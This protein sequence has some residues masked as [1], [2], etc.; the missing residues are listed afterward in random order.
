V[1][2]V[3]AIV[4]HK[5]GVGKTTSAV[6]IAACWGEIGKRVLVIDLDPQG[7]A[8]LSFGIDDDGNALL[9]ALQKT[10]AL[11]VLSTKASGV[12]LVPAGRKVAEAR[13]R[14]VGAIGSELL[15]R[16]LRHTE[17][18]WDFVIIDCP[19]SLGILTM[20][21]LKA[22]AHVVIPVEA[23]Y[24]SY[25]G[26]SQMF[27]AVNTF[28]SQNPVL[29]IRAIIPCRAQARRR[30]HG[31]FLEMMEK[32]LPGGIGPMIRENVSL[33]EAP[34][35]GLPV[36]L[37]FPNSNGAYDYRRAAQWLLERLL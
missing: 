35:S 2:Q 4:N 13:Q 16:C 1:Q 10:T 14:F 8:S 25:H 18:E 21:A 3:V 27:Q 22:S 31:E 5:G 6:N 15:I 28:R 26:L 20:N 11:P 12:D 9:Q 34:G 19:P 24:L 30:I 23:N 37:Y 32:L 17:G 7:S 36:V 29:A 33:A